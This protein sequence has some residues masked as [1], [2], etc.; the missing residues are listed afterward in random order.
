MDDQ[1]IIRQ[2]LRGDKEAFSL[3]VEKYHRRLLGLAFQLVRDRGLA[4]DIG[5]EA[6]LRAYKNLA[7]FDG[8]RGVPF[9]AWL[10]TLTRNLAVDELRRQVRQRA[11]ASPAKDELPE[12]PDP[13]PGTLADL[14][15]REKRVA[16]AQ[17]LDQVPEPYRSTLIMQ[18]EGK[19]LA[20]I[21]RGQGVAWG[22]VK[23]RLARAKQ[24]LARLFRN[25][26]K[27]DGF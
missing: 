8:E 18:M 21:A 10:F 16:L 20:Q 3:L 13:R 2:V 26:E 12:L 7:S 17:C 6:F 25:K 5:Q 14:L 11:L 1:T 19:T 22:T 4:E 24:S 27:Q 9:S 23:S 15:D